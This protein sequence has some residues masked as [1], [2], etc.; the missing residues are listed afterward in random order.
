MTGINILAELKSWA[1]ISSYLMRFLY[2]D[3]FYFFL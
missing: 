3:F 1:Q 2:F